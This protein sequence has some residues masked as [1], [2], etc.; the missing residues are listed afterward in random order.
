MCLNNTYSLRCSVNS[1]QNRR[2]WL[3]ARG[4]SLNFCVFVDDP[5]KLCVK[6]LEAYLIEKFLLVR[7][8]FKEFELELTRVSILI[9]VQR[10]RYFRVC[11]KTAVLSR[12]KPLLLFREVAEINVVEVIEFP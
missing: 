7:H 6:L 5:L 1:V 8:F 10:R 2:G 12:Q 9:I 3:R 4:Q 11:H